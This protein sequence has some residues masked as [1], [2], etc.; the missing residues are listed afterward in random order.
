MS[1]ETISNITR[2][3]VAI[4]VVFLLSGVVVGL[5]GGEPAPRANIIWSASLL[6]AAYGIPLL[7]GSILGGLAI[8]KWGWIPGLFFGIGSVGVVSWVVNDNFHLVRDG[9]QLGP[10]VY[11]GEVWLAVSVWAAAIGGLLFFVAGFVSDV[12][13]WIGGPTSRIMVNKGRN[14]EQ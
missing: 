7:V 5:V 11:L 8:A 1:G 2:V 13:M 9:W 14:G 12:P 6:T 3:L 4:L 10:F